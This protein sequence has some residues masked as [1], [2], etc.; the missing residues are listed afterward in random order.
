MYHTT[1]C[2]IEARKARDFL[3]HAWVSNPMRVQNIIQVNMIM[4]WD[5]ISSNIKCAE[6]IYG[7]DIYALKGKTT[8]H[9][10]KPVSLDYVKVLKFIFDTHKLI[11]VPR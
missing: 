5:V 1:T 3:S 7:S 11:Q 4:N 8:R 9:T 10:P 6:E 2:S